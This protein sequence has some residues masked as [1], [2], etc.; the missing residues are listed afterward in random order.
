MTP[1]L[2]EYRRCLCGAWTTRDGKLCAEPELPY[3]LI[4]AYRLFCAACKP[5]KSKKE[6][7]K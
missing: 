3:K 6:P 4:D 7:K 5:V 1:P 2:P